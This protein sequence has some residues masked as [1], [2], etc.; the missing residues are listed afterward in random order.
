MMFYLKPG[1]PDDDDKTKITVQVIDVFGDSATVNFT[2]KVSILV[3][4]YHTEIR[5]N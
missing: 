2:I 5:S 1:D 4:K 3:C